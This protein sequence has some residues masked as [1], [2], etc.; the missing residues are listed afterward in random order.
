[1]LPLGCLP[2]W[3]RKGVTLLAAAENKQITGKRGFQQ[4][5]NL[6]KSHKKL[7]GFL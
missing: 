6:G 7:D 2:L 4:I 5:P 3:G 1:M